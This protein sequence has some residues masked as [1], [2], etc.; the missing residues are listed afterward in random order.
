[1]SIFCGNEY[2]FSRFIFR[3]QAAIV[4]SKKDTIHTKSE[5]SILEAIKVRVGNQCTHSL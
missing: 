1:M 5:R 2:F 3:V 4:R